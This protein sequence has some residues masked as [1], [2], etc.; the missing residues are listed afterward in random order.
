MQ[1]SDL[2][3]RV[4][5]ISGGYYW[6]PSWHLRQRGFKA[7]PLGADRGRAVTAAAALNDSA[8]AYLARDEEQHRE[9]IAASYSRA[10]RRAR[11]RA[12]EF[13]REFCL[14]E[15][16]LAAAIDRA[17]GNCEISGI[18]F[19]LSPQKDRRRLP[20]A[21]SIDRVDSRQGYVASN[22]RLVCICV[23]IMVSDFGDE[24]FRRVCREVTR[25]TKQAL[26][27]KISTRPP[28]HVAKL[29]TPAGLE[30]ATY[31]LEGR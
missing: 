9:Q 30:P 16:D 24:V 21:P 6:R 8:E 2:P 26:G 23:N 25:K 27:G 1:K 28:E 4:R 7:M 19:D 14:S 17:A 13:S 31:R 15:A 18:E 11:K 12:A 22:I 29:A 20:F 5:L 3:K 10:F